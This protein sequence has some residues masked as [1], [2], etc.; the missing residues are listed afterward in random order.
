MEFMP[1]HAATA[2][3]A[4]LGLGAA[5]GVAVLALIGAIFLKRRR[6]L[7]WIAG[8]GL[9]AVAIYAGLLFSSSAASKERLL[10][11]GEKKYFCEIDCHLAYSVEG[12]EIN[13][14]LGPPARPLRARGRW[15]VVRLRT[16]FDEETVSSRRGADPIQPKPRRVYVADAAGTRYA[17]SAEGAAAL[18]AIGRIS[19]P[20]TQTLRPGE[21][22]V[23]LLVFDLPEDVRAPRLFVGA[24]DPITFLLI[25]HEE[26][27]SHAKIWFR[28]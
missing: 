18:A 24:K 26:S 9:A 13:R 19:A 14:Q 8:F 7:P 4:L 2:M 5:L 21:S 25:G 22:Y 16:W 28:L 23:T 3:L 17:P 15:H 20:L 27:P 10:T 1:Q 11:L 12:T 6:L